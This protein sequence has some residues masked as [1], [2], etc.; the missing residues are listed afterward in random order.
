RLADDVAGDEGRSVKGAFLFSA[1]LGYRF[2]FSKPSFQPIAHP[3]QV[4]NRLLEDMTQNIHVDELGRGRGFRFLGGLPG[5]PIIVGG[6]PC[7]RF[8]NL[9]RDFESLQEL[10]MLEQAPVVL[11]DLQAWI[12]LVD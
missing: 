12:A 4:A 5:W 7:K 1:R 2:F 6:Q 3:L 10:V 8:A 11:R 9:V